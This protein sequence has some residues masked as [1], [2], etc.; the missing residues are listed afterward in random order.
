MK[1]LIYFASVVVASSVLAG[2]LILKNDKNIKSQADAGKAGE[3][4]ESG[5]TFVGAM[6]E[7]KGDRDTFLVRV[8]A[9]ETDRTV[10]TNAIAATTGAT[11]T[12]GNK[13][14][15]EIDSLQREVLILK[16]MVV[17]LKKAIIADKRGK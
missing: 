3:A 1:C 5:S 4:S 11:K 9:F 13:I 10:A 17:D 12:M 6:D 16:Q 2:P 8:N 15:N 14:Q 7:F